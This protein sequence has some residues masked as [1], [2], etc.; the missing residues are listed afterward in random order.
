MGRD[1]S[2]L[3][4]LMLEISLNSVKY[5]FSL[6]HFK[7]HNFS[8]PISVKYF[9][10]LSCLF[11]ATTSVAQ[12]SITADFPGGNV[13]V[14]K[15]VADTVYFK[16]DLRMT[17]GEWFYWNFEAVSQ[18][19]KKWYFKAEKKDVLTNMGA[20]SS[21]NCGY[22]WQW[23]NRKDD[24]GP[25]WF[26]FDF[27]SGEHVRLSMG[28]PYTQENFQSFIKPYAKNKNLK[29]SY[30]T[31]TKKGRKVEKIRIGN[32]DG[33]PSCKILITARHHAS[34]MMA[35]YIIEGII[36]TL[37]SD[38]PQITS[39]LKTTEFM[40]IPFVD[41]DGVEDGDQGKNRLPRDHNRDYS[42]KSIYKSTRAIRKLKNTWIGDSEWIAIDLHDPWIK[43]PGAERICFVGSEQKALADEQVKLAQILEKTVQE[44]LKYDQKIN[45][46][47]WG[48]SWNTDTN[49]TKGSSF[50]TW[51]SSFFNKGL[52][53]S[54]TIEFPYALI[55]GQ[56][57]TASSARSFGQNLIYAL[58]DYT[59]KH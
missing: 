23:I 7:L 39:L 59:H 30:L 3:K 38:D 9:A 31:T 22:S 53:V 28:Q 18:E 6:F 27:K 40:I 17:A 54:A 10:F 14:D 49:N 4:R 58:K 5:H 1:S 16:P 37:L 41:K 25:N 55:D 12:L 50:T 57:V 34:E 2:R 21:L 46:L 51:A 42:G 15:V 29:L 19:S 11:L 24:L 20:A 43:G 56:P 48:D 52:L 13:V 47:A 8:F 45:Y 26:S 32:F 44:R 35:N 33:S 36:E